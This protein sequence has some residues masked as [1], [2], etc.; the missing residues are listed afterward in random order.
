MFSSSV[1]SRRGCRSFQNSHSRKPKGAA[2]AEFGPSLAC[3]ILLVL[4]PMIDIG[5]TLIRYW[6]AYSVMNT[7]IHRLSMEDKM[8]DVATKLKNDVGWQKLIDNCGVKV[9][10]A[11]LALH[12]VSNANQDKSIDVP[13][14]ALVPSD[15]LPNGKAGPYIYYINLTLSTHMQ[16]LFQMKFGGLDI[17]GLTAPVPMKFTASSAWENL[18]RD[19][20]STEFF[21]NE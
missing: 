11:A 20:D 12:I 13:Y 5:T 7:T 8:S 18:G 6:M 9:D 1:S 16:P 17:P 19:P 3:Y 14:P 21:L 15:W 2:L 10:S 4:L